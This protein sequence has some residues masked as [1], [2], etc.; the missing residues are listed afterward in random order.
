MAENKQLLGGL[1]VQDQFDVNG[2]TESV[3]EDL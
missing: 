1:Y 3:S 2:D